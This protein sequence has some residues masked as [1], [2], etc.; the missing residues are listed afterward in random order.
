MAVFSA[1]VFPPNEFWDFATRLYARGQAKEACLELQD[2]RGLDVNVILFCCWVASSGR[3]GFRS[4]ELESALE[5]VSPWRAHVIQVLRDL[6]QH[7]K[8][9]VT[10]APKPLSD[11]LRRVVVEC[12]LHSEHVEALM[13]HQSMV[14]VGTGTF[15][16]LQQLED[17]T[18]NLLRYLIL[19]GI[20]PDNRDLGSLIEVLA[21]AFPEEGRQRVETTVG[22]MAFRLNA[23]DDGILGSA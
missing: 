14:R 17:S 22:G 16:R 19:S 15:D 8:G 20:S 9:D 2:H 3:G 23:G 11:D 10:P 6:R 5:S 7:L 13:L 1:G 18:S 12:E 4:G 21:A